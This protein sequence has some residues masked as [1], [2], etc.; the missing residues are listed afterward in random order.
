M[1]AFDPFLPLARGT[2]LQDSS[3]SRMFPQFAL[4]WQFEVARLAHRIFVGRCFDVVG[5]RKAARLIEAIKTILRHTPR[6]RLSRLC[7]ASEARD[8][9]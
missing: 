1:S 2:R 3:L 6:P 4:D 5:L 8:F 7:D 9:T